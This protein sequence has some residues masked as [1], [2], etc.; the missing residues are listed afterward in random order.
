V[1]RQ[2]PDG[3][4]AR[5]V[6]RA[7]QLESILS[8]LGSSLGAQII[9]GGRVQ[10]RD[11]PLP[12]GSPE[13]DR[14]LGGGFPLGA[15]SEISGT[16]SSGRT[17]LA[18]SLLATTTARGELVGWVDAADAF[19]PV[20]AERKGVDLERVL[21]VRS[22]SEREALAATERLVRTEGFPLVLLDLPRSKS[23]SSGWLRLARL[24]AASRTALLLLTDRRLA[25][26]HASLALEMQPARARFTGCPALLEEL[27]TRMVVLRNRM[28]NHMGNRTA[29][30]DPNSA[31]RVLVRAGSPSTQSSRAPHESV[32]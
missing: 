27:E 25:G 3:A 16:A 14:L 10:E 9:R 2:P 19:D 8:D 13:I 7:Q 20:S 30:V 23:S 18:L 6:R 4:L 26:S 21:W 5:P 22:P 17:S 28:G 32:A 24:C 1:S 11:G 31:H 12:A 15:L 29:P